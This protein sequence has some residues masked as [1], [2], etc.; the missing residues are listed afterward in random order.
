M[1]T[2]PEGRLYTWGN[3]GAGNLGHDNNDNL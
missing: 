1:I 3:G 2:S